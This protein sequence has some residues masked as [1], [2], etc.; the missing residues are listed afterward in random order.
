MEILLRRFDD[1]YYV[2]KPAIWNRNKF[3]IE[4]SGGFI[5]TPSYTDILAVRDDNRNNHVVCAGCGELIENNPESIERHFAER[6]AQKDCLQCR[7]LTTYGSPRDKSVAYTAN[8]D[9][10]YHMVVHSNV[11]LGFKKTFWTTN[12]HSADAHA[13]CIFNKCRRDGV[14]PIED[15]FI[16]YPDLFEKQITVDLLNAKK[17]PYERAR[18]GY[19][20]Y[21][22]KC[23]GTVKAC[24]NELGIVDHFRVL[25]RGWGYNL[26]YSNLHNKLFYNDNG[27]YNENVLDVMTDAKRELL[28][29]KFSKLF[30]EAETNEE[31]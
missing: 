23:R 13:N 7:H 27:K 2:W 18:N 21:D 6:E 14:K 19:F 24:V 30:E 31:E 20:E 1:K 9:G 25:N 29:E 22:M 4:L 16:K 26:Y 10:T 17:Y 15:V 3:D 11:D 28:L 5:F 8:G 12:I